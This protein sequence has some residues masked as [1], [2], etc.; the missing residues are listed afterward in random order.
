MEVF[1]TN[2]GFLRIDEMLWRLWYPSEKSEKNDRQ[3]HKYFRLI[4]IIEMI[5]KQECN[6]ASRIECWTVKSI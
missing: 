1:R 6:N 5:C 3:N 4:H 2:L